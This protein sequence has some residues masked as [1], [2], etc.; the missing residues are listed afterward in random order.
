MLSDDDPMG[1][2]RPGDGTCLLM[3]GALLAGRV[4]C[5]ASCAKAGR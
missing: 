2:M 3:S 5:S 4:L 1:D